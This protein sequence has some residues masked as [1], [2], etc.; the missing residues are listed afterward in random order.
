VYRPGWEFKIA[1]VPAGEVHFNNK[2]QVWQYF[3]PFKIKKL[4]LRLEITGRKLKGT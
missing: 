3:F 4:L 1:S 2:I